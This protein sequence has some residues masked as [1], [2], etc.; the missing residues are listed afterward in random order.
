[1][2]FLLVA[3]C[4]YLTTEND[5]GLVETQWTPDSAAI[6]RT[7]ISLLLIHWLCIAQCGD[8]LSNSDQWLHASLT[9]SCGIVFSVKSY[10]FVSY[11]SV[12]FVA[13]LS[14]RKECACQFK[15]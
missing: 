2:I 10:F 9:V 5:S 14:V 8:T 11:F 13:A 7:C 4:N 6:V 3:V 15:F 12:S 1:V